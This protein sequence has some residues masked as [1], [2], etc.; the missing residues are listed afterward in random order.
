DHPHTDCE[1]SEEHQ[2]QFLRH[3]NSPSM[4]AV[5]RAVPLGTLSNMSVLRVGEL[6]VKAALA[7]CYREIKCSGEGSIP[8]YIAAVV[9]IGNE[10]H[11]K[12]CREVRYFGEF[13]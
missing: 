1:N 6:L 5:H 10:T 12:Q 8:I 2:R 11:K 3:D 13:P 7:R 4:L 9:A